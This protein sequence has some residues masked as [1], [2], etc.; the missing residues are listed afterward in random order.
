M[1]GILW[2]NQLVLVIYTIRNEGLSFWA[3]GRVF[4]YELLMLL[5]IYKTNR[6]GIGRKLMI[7]GR[8]LLIIFALLTFFM[9]YLIKSA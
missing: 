5:P 3:I 6:I 2:V 1:G 8:V 7:I 4:N 9:I